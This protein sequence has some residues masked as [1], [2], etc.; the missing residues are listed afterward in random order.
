MT[1]SGLSPAHAGRMHDLLTTHVE[2]GRLPGLV[3]LISRRGEVHAD[4]IGTMALGGGAPMRQD[5][6]FR[7]SSMTKPI[8]AAAAMILVDEGRLHLD[9]PV[10]RLLPELSDR[11]VLARLDGPLDETVP[12]ARPLTLRDLLTFR[13]GFGLVWGPQDALPI[14]RAAA[15]LQLQAFGP[16]RLRAVPPP[17]TWI[18]RF[19]TL[20]LMAQPDARWLYNTGAE[21]LGVL[22][23][24]AAG[25]PLGALLRRRVFDPLGMK[26]TGFSVPPDQAERLPVSYIADPATGALSVFDEAAGR[27]DWSQPPAFPSAAGGL[28][29]TADDCLAFGQMLLDRGKIAG[30]RLLSSESV[31]AMTADQIT[32]AQKAASGGSLDPDFW[33]GQ[34]WGFGLAVATP[35]SEQPGRPRGFGWD[36]GLGTS[37]WADPREGM[38]GIL[39]TQRCEYPSA[40]GLY[41][42]FWRAAYGG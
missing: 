7:I 28:V 23:A 40:A 27:S 3:T 35:G 24:R 30:G 42:D 5:T 25:E 12:A 6:I 13:M 32:P 22:L 18:Q 29:S 15:D 19:A 1:P 41:G 37:M 33:K 26:D 39:M 34:G 2:R 8:T 21:V 10:D 17:D 20:P 38:V 11:R 9:E 4:V 31:D 14:Q 16:P 36:G